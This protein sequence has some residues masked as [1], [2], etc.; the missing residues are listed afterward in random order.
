MSK[1]EKLPATLRGMEPK[2]N[3]GDLVTHECD[4]EWFGIILEVSDRSL[5]E[6]PCWH[7]KV[8]FPSG[9]EAWHNDSRLKLQA[10]CKR[11]K[12]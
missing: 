8:R 3:V 11:G 2:F 4:D 6:I 1:Q 12:L 9:Y 10:R 7:C 5:G